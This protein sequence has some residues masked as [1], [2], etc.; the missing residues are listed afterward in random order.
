LNGSPS[1]RLITDD[2]R[3]FFRLELPIHPAFAQ[4]RVE[5]GVEAGVALHDTERRI[6]D[7]LRG[8]LRGVKDLMS[9]S[10]SQNGERHAPWPALH[11]RTFVQGTVPHGN[12]TPNALQ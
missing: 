6:L 5:A 7:A 8:S 3:T 12:L 4:A 10:G 11:K 9:G 1:L 2:E